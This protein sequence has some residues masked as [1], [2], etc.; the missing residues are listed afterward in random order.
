MQIRENFSN[1]YTKYIGWN[2]MQIS[3]KDLNK[4]ANKKWF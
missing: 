4:Y 2:N 1:I 3:S